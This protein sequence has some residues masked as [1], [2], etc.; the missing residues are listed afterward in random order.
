MT[1]FIPRK[2]EI[3][4]RNPS[5]LQE[6]DWSNTFSD[7]LVSS[8]DYI[9]IKDGVDGQEATLFDTAN[10]D[11]AQLN[12]TGGWGAV[13]T[14]ADRL[15]VDSQA[16]YDAVDGNSWTWA[17]R[18]KL[19]GL[20][21]DCV[22]A[23]MGSPKLGTMSFGPMLDTGGEFRFTTKAV[24]GWYTALLKGSTPRDLGVW[25]DATII[26][27][28]ANLTL[29]YNGTPETPVPFP[30]SNFPAAGGTAFSI[31]NGRRFSGSEDYFTEN[32]AQDY[33]RFYS[34][35][36]SV[37]EVVDLQVNPYQILKPRQKYWLL[38]I[39][40]GS[41]PIMASALRGA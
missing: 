16:I 19:N 25:C 40:A 9:D 20:S 5:T 2:K 22:L 7:G 1:F 18:F 21:N 12:I 6:I 24:A 39:A 32:N 3:W 13:G 29:V 35:N 33:F 14:N 41:A 31:G 27:D 34:R 38:D 10:N 17:I 4:Q 15:D 37:E 26:Y 28:G 23:G 11:S 36:L 30:A 8:F